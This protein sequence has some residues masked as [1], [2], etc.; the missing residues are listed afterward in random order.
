MKQNKLFQF[1]NLY[2]RV[3]IND[4]LVNLVSG[5][6][7][8]LIL[9]YLD[10]I[11]WENLIHF[12]IRGTVLL[13]PF[14]VLH[15][16]FF[17]LKL[18][19]AWMPQDR[20]SE[21]DLQ[22]RI[23]KLKQLLSAATSGIFTI[24]ILWAVAGGFAYYFSINTPGIS[25]L[26]GLLALIT[27]VGMA[28]VTWLVDTIVVRRLLMSTIR[29]YLSTFPENALSGLNFYRMSS[30]NKSA[31]AVFYLFLLAIFFTLIGSVNSFNSM[32]E[33]QLKEFGKL[34][35]D[36]IAYRIQ[37]NPETRESPEH[38]RAIIREFPKLIGSE[39]VLMSG[40]PGSKQKMI[41][42]A[43]EGKNWV[44]VKKDVGI[45]TLVFR[46]DRAKLRSKVISGVVAKGGIV[47]LVMLLGVGIIVVFQVNKEFKGTLSVINRIT[48]EMADGNLGDA[49]RLY[50][51]DEFWNLYQ[52]L[53]VV[54]NNAGKVIGDIREHA[55]LLNLNIRVVEEVSH[56]L[57]ELAGGQR[58]LVR[59]AGDAVSFV[60]G[61]ADNLQKAISEL[62]L[63]SERTSSTAIE[64]AASISEVKNSMG[65]L[66]GLADMIAGNVRENTSSLKSFSSELKTAFGMVEQIEGSVSQL[67]DSFG[68]RISE[69]GE[70]H[71]EIEKQLDA[72]GGIHQGFG[73]IETHLDKLSAMYAD[74]QDS[75]IVLGKEIARIESIARIMDDFI[76]QAGIL[77]LNAAILAARNDS[78]DSGF[79]VIADEIK[80]LAERTGDSTGEIRTIVNNT[81]HQLSNLEEGTKGA[82]IE[83]R[84]AKGILKKILSIQLDGVERLR[85]E[86]GRIQFMLDDAGQEKSRV[87]TLLDGTRMLKLLL[88]KTE[89]VLNEQVTV[90]EKSMETSDEMK[91]MAGQVMVAAQ[92]QTVGANQIA[93]ASESIRDLSGDAKSASEKVKEAV[94]DIVRLIRTIE[95]NSEKIRS[96]SDT[97]RAVV[98]DFSAELSSLS[99]EIAKFR[100]PDRK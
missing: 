52:K 58:P 13:F 90:T 54:K 28:P 84:R 14:Y 45:G 76:D 59:N 19:K 39:L 72:A 80:E 38:A 18:K 37:A 44:I 64:F 31:L 17:Y 6:A 98:D 42:P 16:V 20:F 30:L 41:V 81:I 87:G 97:L 100:L 85:E 88:A 35:L 95:E 10:V 63:I 51:T 73:E 69:L 93:A 68:K 71:F 21:M 74:Y 89:D 4:F 11:Q 92:E 23:Y 27:F 96:K 67:H 50:A 78:L 55:R 1:Q 60:E 82:G 43:H 99:T 29:R 49:E 94:E 56:F 33:G 70:V 57:Q 36:E 47:L 15:L 65:K 79:G 7:A 3:V 5:F 12:I 32:L 8:A 91:E 75:R 25:R 86:S 26:M 61:F 62:F 66:V 40:S 77:A 34:Q 22:S 9:F 24:V 53:I 83:F 2:L 46:T 48:D